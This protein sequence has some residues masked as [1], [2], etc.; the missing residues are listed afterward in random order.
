MIVA[1]ADVISYFWLD[2]GR[3]DTARAVRQ[4]EETWAAPSLWRSEFRTV[5][6][7]HMRHRGLD[8]ADALRIAAR[9]ETDLEDRTYDVSTDAVLRLVDQ[10]GHFS[11]LLSGCEYVALAQQLGVSLVTGDR[12]VV[13]QFPDTAILLEEAVE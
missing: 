10:T 1:D 2:V 8:R 11:R 6:A 13:E 4:R 3:T 12:A 5:L 9:A 7:Q